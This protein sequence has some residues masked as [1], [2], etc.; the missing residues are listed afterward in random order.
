[1]LTCLIV[2]SKSHGQEFFGFQEVLLGPTYKRGGE[3][4]PNKLKADLRGGILLMTMP[5]TAE[6]KYGDYEFRWRFID[7]ISRLRPGKK[8]KF[9]MTGRRIG[10]NADSN[11]NT[12]WMSSSNQG[13][14]LAKKAGIESLANNL[15]VTKSQSNVVAWPVQRNNKA[16]GTVELS[17]NVT[18]K[19][20]YF[21]FRFDFS[22]YPYAS[23]SKACSFEVVYVFGKNAAPII[24][25]KKN[26]LR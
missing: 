4:K 22:S 1:M 16:S 26:R 8:Y 6:K 10:G 13:S 3:F 15:T 18:A 9:E 25:P 2:A 23:N 17:K 14:K 7:D 21:T 19:K 12:A 24:K 20:T 11:T 5:D